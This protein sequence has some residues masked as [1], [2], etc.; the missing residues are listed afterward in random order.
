MK[1]YSENSPRIL[2]LLYSMPPMSMGGAEM[3]GIKLITYLNELGVI[4]KVITW[5]KLWHSRNGIYK[6]ISFTRIRSI[7]NVI[8]DLPSLFKSVKA[9]SGR[10]VKI[11]FNDTKEMT[12]RVT[13]KVGLA[14]IIRYRLFYFNCLVYLWFRRK[15]FDVIHVHMMEWPAIV[16]VWLGKRLNKP[17]VI[18]DSTM[19][20]IF[21]ILRY[22]HGKEKQQEIAAYAHCIAM[23]QV[24]KENYLEAG[25]PQKNITVIPN[26]IET[27]S[28]GQTNKSW[29]QKIIFV[30]NLTQQPAKGV[31]ILLLAWKRIIMKFPLATLRIVGE[32]NLVAYRSFAKE[33]GI[34]SSVEFMGKQKEIKKFML[35]ADIFVLPSRREGMS[36]ALMEAM[37][38]GMPVVA[39]D[40]SGSRDLVEHTISGLLVPPADVAQ[41]AEALIYMLQ[42]PEQ[43]ISMGRKG[44]ES[45][46]EKCDINNVVRQYA[47]LYNKILQK[48]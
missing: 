18:K 39:T 27:T 26:G 37:M 47:E 38:C 29:Q 14:M 43:A 1:S 3:Q 16:G 21:N 36:N 6:G 10:P 9:P 32:G 42:H 25:I 31:D 34:E 15:E 20:G 48:Y 45:V 24:I 23:T 8:T 17:V 5:G 11:L 40:V 19:N 4:T 28:L 30:G 35:E 12:N 22:P 2:M 13:G 44:Y 7:L 41:L 33:N 46:K